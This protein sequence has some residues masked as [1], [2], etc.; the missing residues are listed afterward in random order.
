VIIEFPSRIH[1]FTVTPVTKFATQN[2][3]ANVGL[4]TAPLVPSVTTAVHASAGSADVVSVFYGAL[5]VYGLALVFGGLL[6]LPLL[7][8]AARFH[9]VKAWACILAGFIAGAICALLMILLTGGG[10][11]MVLG[12]GC[13]GA[14]AAALF[15][16]FWRLGPDP[17]P[18]FARSWT[19]E[20]SGSR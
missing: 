9:Q 7:N 3:A 2:A 1:D 8:L 17:S 12:Y 20:F 15:W 4:I 16:I 13:Q 11:D 5:L 18:S 14:G 6:G 19:Q 10:L